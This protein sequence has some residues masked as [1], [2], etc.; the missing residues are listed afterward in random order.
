MHK[1][2]PSSS[3]IE[4]NLFNIYINFILVFCFVCWPV[5]EQ[6]LNYILF[7]LLCIVDIYL[8][9][10]LLIYILYIYIDR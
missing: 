9:I 10:S 5:I 4:V 8:G 6:V 7:L 2:S 3:T 1:N